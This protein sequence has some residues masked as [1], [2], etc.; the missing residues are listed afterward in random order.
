MTLRNL[1][2]QIDIQEL[3]LISLCFVISCNPKL[4][5]TL[6]SSIGSVFSVLTL[7]YKGRI[8]INNERNKNKYKI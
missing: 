6:A 4:D 1:Y 7:T 8:T 2:P 3:T 5:N